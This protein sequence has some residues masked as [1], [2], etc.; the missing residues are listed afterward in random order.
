M[1]RLFAILVLVV[2]E[3]YL[4]ESHL[5]LRNPHS[6]ITPA[7][8]PFLSKTLVNFGELSPYTQLNKYQDGHKFGY[9]ALYK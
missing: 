6:R 8:H 9:K 3:V 4:L 1:L 2:K 7:L 5:C